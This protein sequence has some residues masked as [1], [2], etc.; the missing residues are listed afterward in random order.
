MKEGNEYYSALDERSGMCA[1]LEI[2][3]SRLLGREAGIR[4]GKRRVSPWVRSKKVTSTVELRRQKVMMIG[5]RQYERVKSIPT[6]LNGMLCS[7]HLGRR[8]YGRVKEEGD[9]P[10]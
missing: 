4:S 8:S 5:M 6:A 1:E 3:E 7:R 9:E 2:E 10:D